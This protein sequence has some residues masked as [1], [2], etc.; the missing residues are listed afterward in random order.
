[1]N[2]LQTK[3]LNALKTNK[4]NPSK[5]GQRKWYNYFIQ[6]DELVWSRNL[7]EGYQ[8]HIYVDES[9]SHHLATYWIGYDLSYNPFL[10]IQ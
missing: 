5:L 1:M 8:I 9:K 2:N 3:I 4:L 7:W 10:K 6:T